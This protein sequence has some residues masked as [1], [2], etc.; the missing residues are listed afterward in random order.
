M[1]PWESAAAPRGDHRDPACAG[2]AEAGGA[3]RAVS[4]RRI[5]PRNTRKDAERRARTAAPHR[6]IP[7]LPRL[8]RFLCPEGASRR[9][10]VSAV[11]TGGAA[12]AAGSKVWAGFG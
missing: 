3:L 1:G 7:R 2:E 8:P 9:Q 11:G 5:E 4:A 6:F 12:A 10:P